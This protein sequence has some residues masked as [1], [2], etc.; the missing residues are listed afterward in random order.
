MHFP[1]H[2][3]CTD[4]VRSGGRT[5]TADVS[6]SNIELLRLFRKGLLRFAGGRMG[7]RGMGTA[8]S[9][10]AR[11]LGGWEGLGKWSSP[12]SPTQRRKFA[13]RGTFWAVLKVSH[14]SLS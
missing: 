6:G 1:S 4:L 2:S 5:Y 8:G 11:P 9:L 3:R 14:G 12:V 7:S 10:V 13:V